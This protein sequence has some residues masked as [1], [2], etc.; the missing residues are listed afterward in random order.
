MRYE[1]VYDLLSGFSFLV[2]AMAMEMVR[3]MVKVIVNGVSVLGNHDTIFE[4]LL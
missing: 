3:V 4:Y 2:S 1:L